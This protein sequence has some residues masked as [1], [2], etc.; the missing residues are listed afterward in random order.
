MAGVRRAFGENFTC[1]DSR[2]RQSMR[3][4]DRSEFISGACDDSGSGFFDRFMG[5]DDDSDRGFFVGRRAT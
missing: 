5:G 1:E 3:G 4:G 2:V